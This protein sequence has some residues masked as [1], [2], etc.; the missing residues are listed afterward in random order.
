MWAEYERPNDYLSEA[1][2]FV[3]SRQG[4]KV[5][6]WCGVRWQAPATLF[7]DFRAGDV[8]TPVE[9][10]TALPSLHAFTPETRGHDPLCL[11]GRARLTRSAMRN[12]APAFARRSR[13]RSSMRTCRSSATST[14]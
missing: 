12:S 8:G 13:P 11:G 14:G 5:D 2:A 10:M 9:A 4:E 6:F 3:L 1:M 7:L